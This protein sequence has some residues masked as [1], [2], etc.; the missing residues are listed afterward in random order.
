[1]GSSLIC[2]II[3]NSIL[4]IAVSLTQITSLYHHHPHDCHYDDD[5]QGASG[6]KKRGNERGLWRCPRASAGCQVLILVIAILMRSVLIVDIFL[7][8]TRWYEGVRAKL[9]S[10][11]SPF[12]FVLNLSSRELE[13]EKKEAEMMGLDF[14]KEGELV[15]VQK[16][17]MMTEKAMMMEKQMMMFKQKQ[18]MMNK[19]KAMMMRRQ[20]E[21]MLK[22]QKPE[23]TR[24]QPQARMFQKDWQS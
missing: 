21:M 9:L 13:E 2:T 5:D 12:A 11:F 14:S 8:F 20:K 15:A 18:M 16:K 23:M 4:F 17:L 6:E 3:L 10:H 1:M 19:Q 7:I 24:L 22:K